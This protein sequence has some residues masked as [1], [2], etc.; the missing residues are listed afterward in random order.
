MRF[1]SAIVPVYW[2][3]A[4]LEQMAS[5]ALHRTLLRSMTAILAG[6]GIAGC[7]QFEYTG[8]REDR[9]AKEALE[10][11]PTPG[12]PGLWR[13]RNAVDAGQGRNVDVAQCDRRP[14]RTALSVANIRE[15]PI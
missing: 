8:E 11:P 15:G 13:C 10:E 12:A 9:E 5:I 6:L 2:Q 1:F 3:Q 4:Q 14:G 7:D